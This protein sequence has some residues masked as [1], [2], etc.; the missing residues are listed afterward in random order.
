MTKECHKL[1]PLVFYFTTLVHDLRSVVT[2]VIIPQAE[3]KNC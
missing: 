3:R 1:K 2:E